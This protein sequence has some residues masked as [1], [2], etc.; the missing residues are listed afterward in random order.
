MRLGITGVRPAPNANYGAII[1][2]TPNYYVIFD[3]DGG[4]SIAHW[5]STA[6]ASSRPASFDRSLPQFE[7][8]LSE[9]E[10]L[11]SMEAPKSER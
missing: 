7:T 3:R 6:A 8:E 4:A 11:Y 2:N 10:K 5:L 1:V 9:I